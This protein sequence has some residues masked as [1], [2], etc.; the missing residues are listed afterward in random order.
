MIA[1]AGFVLAASG[2]ARFK[3][4]GP[5]EA[6]NAALR[7]QLIVL[8]RKVQGRVRLSDSDRRF[9][10]QLYRWFPSILQVV[11]SE[12][13]IHWI[14]E[15]RRITT[16]LRMFAIALLFVRL[17]C[18]RFKSRRRLE[19]EVLVLRHQL[20]VLQLRAPRRL[21]LTWVD[22]VLFVWLYRGFPRILNAITVLRPETVVRW[23]R[24]GSGA[25]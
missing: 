11:G 24:K 19:A 15:H 3:S 18:D 17:L 14:R 2:R 16:L 4:K 10:V 1:P 23:H 20:N 22:R 13:P 6:E 9:F 5:L 21:C 7:H 8:R 25:F 12:N